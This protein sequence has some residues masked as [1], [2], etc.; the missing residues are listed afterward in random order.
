MSDQDP[1]FY[2][3]EYECTPDNTS[4][5]MFWGNLASRNHIFIQTDEVD[6]QTMSGDY[7][8]AIDNEEAFNRIATYM[9][10]NGYTAHINLQSVPECDENAYQKHIEDK[11]AAETIEDYIP[12]SWEDGAA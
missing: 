2:I 1:S 3:N 8:F 5:F 11:V 9:I 10:N 7:G 6:E 12:E 4:L